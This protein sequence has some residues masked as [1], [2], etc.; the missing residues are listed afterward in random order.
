MW[1]NLD[2]DGEADQMAQH[3]VRY[4]APAVVAHLDPLRLVAD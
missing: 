2:L 3:I 4:G 1:W